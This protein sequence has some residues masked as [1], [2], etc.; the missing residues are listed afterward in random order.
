MRSLLGYTFFVLSAVLGAAADSHPSAGINL[1]SLCTNGLEHCAEVVSV[2]TTTPSKA[3]PF[4]KKA[5]LS[6]ALRHA[7]SMAHKA[8][9]IVNCLLLE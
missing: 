9:G 6:N 4:G 7:H 1:S 8:S 3:V 2:T 5:R